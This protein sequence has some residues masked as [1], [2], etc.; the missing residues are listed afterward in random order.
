MRVLFDLLRA[1]E[2]EFD[3]LVT[4]DQSL[5]NQQNLSDRRVGR[6]GRRRGRGDPAGRLPG[7]FVRAVTAMEPAGWPP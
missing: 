1:A 5:R 6:I 2:S 4:T 3:L 7:A